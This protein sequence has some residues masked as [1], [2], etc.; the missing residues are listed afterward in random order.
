[1][2]WRD[3]IKADEPATPTEAPK[4]SWRDT[5][6]AEES[7]AAPEA[8]PTRITDETFATLRPSFAGEAAKVDE[9]V[10]AA[11]K[12]L[13]DFLASVREGVPGAGLMQKLGAA[14]RATADDSGKPY[15][16]RY[17]SQL[18]AI[19]SDR[20]QRRAN[21]PS[22]AKAGEGLGAMLMPTPGAGGTKLFVDGTGRLTGKATVKAAEGLPGALKR[23]LANAGVS[24]ADKATR[25]NNLEDAKDDALQAG[26]VTGSAQTVFE[27]LGGL[28]RLAKGVG[29]SRTLKALEPTLSQQKLVQDRGR[30]QS[31]AREMLDED[32]IRL[33]SNVD[34]MAPRIDALLSEKGKRI[35]DI[36]EAADKAGAE[37]NFGRLA[38]KGSAKDAFSEATNETA[39]EAAAAYARNADNF[40][41]VPRR[42]LADAHEEVRALDAQ[43]PFEKDAAKLTPAQQAFKEL[44]SDIVAQSDDQ[45]RQTLPDQF[46][47]YLGLK[48]QFGLLKDG[49]KMLATA[50]ARNAKNA[51]FPMSSLLAAN[52]AAKQGGVEGLGKAALAGAAVKVMKERGNAAVAVTADRMSQILG[53]NPARL[54]K[55]AKPLIDAAKR[56]NQALMVTHTLLMNDPEYAAML[57][58]DA[59]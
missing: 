39:Q 25:A 5:V 31:L 51:T 49:D 53:Q 7:G 43:I 54:G 8:D 23:I 33:G 35:G 32:V 58:E 42:S 38:A 12:N 52:A 11:P 45:V 46:D 14:L 24:A 34:A 56:G 3:T 57:N 10:K 37:I 4:K 47:E 44:R 36:R 1:M 20:D 28:G 27:A 55:F 26:G 48:D 2:G 21:N 16:E 40:A 15:G 13:D 17:D 9:A 29:E 19:E 6:K 22:V 41:K 59:K 30:A 50:T 18:A